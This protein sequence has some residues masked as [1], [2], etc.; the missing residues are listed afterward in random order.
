MGIVDSGG[1]LCVMRGRYNSLGAKK[2]SEET[3]QPYE[4]QQVKE[5]QELYQ[6]LPI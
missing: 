4:V 1:S 5:L 3:K 2:Q 6:N